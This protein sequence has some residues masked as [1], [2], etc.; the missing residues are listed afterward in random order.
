MRENVLNS[1]TSNLFR[2]ENLAP[3][4][5]PGTTANPLAF[6]A[7]KQTRVRIKIQKIDY[8]YNRISP[9]I[10]NK[11]FLMKLEMTKKT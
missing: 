8:L 5:T 9:F 10:L 2:I 7:H 1:F 6:Y 3:K 4:Q 11:R